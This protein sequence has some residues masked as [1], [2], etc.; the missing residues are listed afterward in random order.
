M[1][2]AS[3]VSFTCRTARTNKGQLKWSHTSFRQWRA[4]TTQKSKLSTWRQPSQIG[5]NVRQVNRQTANL[6]VKSILL[7][8]DCPFG[9]LYGRWSR[10]F[11]GD[12]VRPPA[13]RPKCQFVPR[14]HHFHG[15][16]VCR[17]TLKPKIFHRLRQLLMIITVIV[18]KSKKY[19]IKW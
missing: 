10:D 12:Y 16:T 1:P 19:V 2:Q 11:V 4:T 14:F 9:S 17:L 18:N 5:A 6:E 15:A 13:S 3:R 8:P 7:T